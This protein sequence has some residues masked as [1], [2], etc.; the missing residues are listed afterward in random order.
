MVHCCVVLCCSKL[1]DWEN[2]LSYYR[3]Y[4]SKNKAVLKQ[5]IDKFGRAN[6]HLSIMHKCAP[7]ILLTFKAERFI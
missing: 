2:Q 7:W 6:L 4:Y 5:W 1:S 3:L